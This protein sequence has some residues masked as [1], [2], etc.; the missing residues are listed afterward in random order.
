LVSTPGLGF[1]LGGVSAFLKKGRHPPTPGGGYSWDGAGA[2]SALRDGSGCGAAGTV[3]P[4][5]R[6]LLALRRDLA[7]SA[8]AQRWLSKISINVVPSSNTAANSAMVKRGILPVPG[9]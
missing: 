4:C 5:A 8:V 3:R 9:F 6:R 1:I 2:V 7:R